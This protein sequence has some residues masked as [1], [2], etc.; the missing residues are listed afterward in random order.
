MAGLILAALTGCAAAP[1]QP[2]LSTPTVSRTSTPATTATLMPE[3]TEPPAAAVP[4]A[5]T[6]LAPRTT[7]E[8]EATL[9]PAMVA[10]T[11][12]PIAT[13]ITREEAG[14]LVPLAPAEVT[15]ES[16]AGA[17]VVRWLGTGEDLAQYEVYRRAAATE[18]WQLL[19][20]VKPTGDNKG[21]YELSDKTAGAAVT[22]LYGVRAVG[23]YGKKSEITEGRKAASP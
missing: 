7:S 16:A 11:S 19:G 22:N 23:L 4:S 3:P 2:A 13:G 17:V 15:V 14:Q 1:T 10:V 9:T 6:P 18:E 20:D 5:H 8:A 21:R 12:A